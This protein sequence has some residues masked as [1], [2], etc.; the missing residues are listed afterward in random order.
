MTVIDSHTHVYPDAIALKASQSTGRFYDIEMSHD[1]RV[2]TLLGRMDEA[3]VDRAVLL[4]VPTTPRQVDSVNRFVKE[5]VQAHPGRFIGFGGVHPHSEQLERDVEMV[6]SG[7]FCGI[8]LHPEIQQV[9]I[10]DEGCSRLFELV[11]GRLPV[12]I[13]AGDP[14]YHCSNPDQ[15][16]KVLDRFPRLTLVCAHLGGWSEWNYVGD[17]LAERGVWVDTSS[18]L[19]AIT[20]QHA[21]GLIKRYGCDRVFFGS[22]YP[23][24]DPADELSAVRALGLTGEELE[25]VLHRN[26]ERFLKAFAPKGGLW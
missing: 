9:S 25:D 17:Y 5:T 1:G 12:Y 18:A 10:V 23:M 2:E 22:D 15:V 26:I 24:W 8:K 16:V 11:E 20:P 19:Y 7:G 21:Y 13:H 6:L 3:G 14:R 4:P